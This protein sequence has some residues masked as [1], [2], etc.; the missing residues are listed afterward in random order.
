MD[1]QCHLN[2]LEAVFIRSI[3]PSMCLQNKKEHVKKLMLF[4]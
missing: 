1:I 4:R 2:V 3:S